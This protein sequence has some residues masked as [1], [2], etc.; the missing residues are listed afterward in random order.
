MVKVM[1]C[2]DDRVQLDDLR[3]RVRD[4]LDRLHTEA[5]I[6]TFDKKDSIPESFLADCGIAL[7]DI[8]FRGRDYNGLDIAKA[9]R[10]VNQ[11]A[12][13]LF[14][15]NYVEYAPEG[16]EVQAFRYLMK[17]DMPR[18]LSGYLELA[19]SKLQQAQETLDVTVSGEP[20]RL[21]LPDILY[22]ESQAHTAVIHLR[23]QPS[24]RIYTPLKHME[25]ALSGRGF[26]RIQKSF[27]VNMRRLKRFQYSGDDGTLL[28]VST[29]TYS[30]QKAQYLLWKGRQ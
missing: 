27:L 22:I 30:Q 26:L 25:A 7:L 5:M 13:I 19:L 28:P 3:R 23:N 17:R 6:C 10:R 21:P 18:K 29:K 8:D 1:I 20:V 2:D 12:V 15:T 24:L 4:I 9:L 11:N 14:I 16:Y